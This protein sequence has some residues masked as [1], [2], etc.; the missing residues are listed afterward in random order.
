MTVK[1]TADR[2]TLGRK[3]GLR[4]KHKARCHG[5]ARRKDALGSE[6]CEAGARTHEVFLKQGT[7]PRTILAVYFE[8]SIVV[9]LRSTRCALDANAG[10]KIAWQQT[11]RFSPAPLMSGRRP[12]LHEPQSPF[13][14][15]G[16]Y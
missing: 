4:I 15:P 9:H 16:W 12:P 2:I 5:L 6:Q 8:A 13:V 1:H 11:R 7:R 10:V 14:L 3:G